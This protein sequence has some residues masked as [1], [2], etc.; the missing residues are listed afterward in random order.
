MAS[1]YTKFKELLK[2]K[3]VFSEEYKL[4]DVA[5]KMNVPVSTL[6]HYTEDN[7]PHFPVELIA[8]LYNA[9]KDKAFLNFM[10]TDTDFLLAPRPQAGE[11][12][13]IKDETLD[14]A[15]SSG[16]LVAQVVAALKDGTLNEDEK[17]E[18][19]KAIDGAQL[20]LEDLRLSVNHKN[21]S[22]GNNGK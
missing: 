15:A 14:A 10:L 2:S 19:L 8:P 22:V 16:S 6:Y 5:R 13:D 4:A 20:E 17:V 7:A 21:N 11:T 1:R 18:I 3:L 12:K 9:T